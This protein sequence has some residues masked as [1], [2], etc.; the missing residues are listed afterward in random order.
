MKQIVSI[1][2]NGRAHE[3]AVRP[4]ATLLDV[5]RD[6]LKLTGTK[7]GCELGDCGA[8]TV[9][10]DGKVVNSCLTLALEADGREVQTVEGISNGADLHPIQQAFVEAGAIQCGFCTPGMVVRAKALL[11]ANPQP[12]DDEIKEALSGNLC[13]CTGYS[14]IIE[15]VDRAALYLQG[16][17][18][19]ELE[20]APQRSAVDLSVVGRRLAKPDAPA[21]AT[22]RAIYT[23]DITLPNM[24]YGK[25]L[26]SPV[27][28]ATIKSIDTKGLCDS[29]YPRYLQ[30]GPA[31]THP[32]E[33]RE[34]PGTTSLGD[35]RD[36]QP[37]LLCPSVSTPLLIGAG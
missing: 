4:G 36:S 20:F 28:H 12:T 26:L 2:V 23:D 5:L 29:L 22:G 11:D 6:E 32:S 15:A 30:P 10:L 24:L 19:Q 16:K 37:H 21:K 33:H 17:Q 1:S 14:K 27:P 8:C 9:L 3:V 7:K 34:H 18:P 35:R 13:R 31:L 25:L